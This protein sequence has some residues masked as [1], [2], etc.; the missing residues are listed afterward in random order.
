MARET[1]HGKTAN[2]E[3]S[4]IKGLSFIG[5]GVDSGYPC[6]V[7]VKNGKIVRIRPL[8]YDSQ[9]DKKQLIPGR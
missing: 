1:N 2:E 5:S 9:Y 6:A 4:Y 8:H 3:K 7:D